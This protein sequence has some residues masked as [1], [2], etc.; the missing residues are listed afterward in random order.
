MAVEVFVALG[1]NLGDPTKNMQTAIE[2]LRQLFEGKMRCSSCWRSAPQ[3]MAPQAA[4]FLNAVVAGFTNLTAYGLLKQLQQIEVAMGREQ[5]HGYHDS[6]IIDLD[7]ITFGDLVSTNKQLIIPHPRAHLRQFVLL[8]LIEL[9]SEMIFPGKN[10]TLQ[11][12]LQSAPAMD[13]NIVT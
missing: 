9:A 6:R 3:D 1:S 11:R 10:E 5:T 13:I 2:Q 8:P 4:D 7:I 12:L